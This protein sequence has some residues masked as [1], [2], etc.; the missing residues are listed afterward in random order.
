[1]FFDEL[2]LYVVDFDVKLCFVSNIRKIFG[3]GIGFVELYWGFDGIL[4]YCVEKGNYC[5]L[6]WILFDFSELIEVKIKG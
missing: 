3:K 2:E 6:F 4:W 5:L 1:M